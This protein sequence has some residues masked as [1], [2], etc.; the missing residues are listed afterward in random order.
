MAQI[1]P[2]SEV[3]KQAIDVKTLQAK[4]K[5]LDVGMIAPAKEAVSDE[6]AEE[7]KSE[8]IKSLDDI[9]RITE[10][11]QENG[12]WRDNM[13]FIV[14]I[15]FG[16]RVS[17][18]RRLRFCNLINDDLT[19][20][21]EFPILE[22]KTKNTRKVQ[23][24]RWITINDAV[25]DAVTMYLEHTQGVSLSDYL[26]KS[27]SNNGGNE[28]K[29]MHRNSIDRILKGIAEDLCLETKVSTHT[30]RKTFCYH[31]MVMSDN[32]P[33]KLLLLS[34]ILGHSSVAV[35]LE[36]IGIT[37]EEISDAY[38][39]LNLGSKK[40]SYIDSGIMELDQQQAM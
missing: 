24:N 22:Q 18:L 14:G 20:K 16:L 6:L 29:P 39:A 3:S 9:T 8:P 15:N 10:Y 21:S 2:M 33:R 4:R 27:N 25:I 26:F 28:N 13:L 5:R 32:D 30:L 34:K 12:R 38:R 23:K 7:R 11:L 17:D 31:Q 40:H 37:N 1:I 35:T 19:F 36:Y